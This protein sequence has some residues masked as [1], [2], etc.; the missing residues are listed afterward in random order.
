MAVMFGCEL[1][2]IELH[3]RALLAGLAN[4]L[5]SHGRRTPANQPQL[6]G[7]PSGRSGSLEAVEHY[8]GPSTKAYPTA[9]APFSEGW[10]FTSEVTANSADSPVSDFA[11][12]PPLAIE[13]VPVLGILALQLLDAGSQ[14][15]DLP[16]ALIRFGLFLSQ[17]FDA[18]FAS[19]RS[20]TAVASSVFCVCSSAFKRGGPRLLLRKGLPSL[21][22][23]GTRFSQS[24]F[25]RD[26]LG[27]WFGW[28]GSPRAPRVHAQ[29]CQGVP[30][31]ADVFLK[32]AGAEVA[33]RSRRLRDRDRTGL[34]P[35]GRLL[36]TP[37]TLNVEAN[38]KQ[39]GSAGPM[40]RTRP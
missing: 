32:R 18:A 37:G 23:S 34:R 25:E 21:A 3:N 28:S 11:R 14:G 35:P 8:A 10:S 1:W 13:N 19:C 2:I 16:L 7:P 27:C 15:P 29:P 12:R 20:R 31:R 17:S 24:G 30:E 6:V 40:A 38:P 22:Q 5:H 33:A 39:R 36:G 4:R 26:A 9:A